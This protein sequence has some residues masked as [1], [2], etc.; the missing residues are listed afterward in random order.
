[1]KF[2]LHLRRL[3]LDRHV[4]Q[5]ALAEQVGVDFTYISKIESGQLAPPSEEVLRKIAQV[6]NTD[7]DDLINQAGKVP[8]EIK[9]T[10]QDNPLLA[11]L[12]RV[13]S[14]RKLPDEVYHQMR[15]L[16]RNAEEA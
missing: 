13:L 3:R 16:A 7:D 1:M 5:R 9:I 10:L 14:E 6:L 2:G 8:A 4:S 11:E 12:L 15:E